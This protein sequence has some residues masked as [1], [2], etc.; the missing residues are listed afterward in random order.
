MA[1]AKARV[2]ELARRDG[3]Q[4]QE[5]G[6]SWSQHTFVVDF[7]ISTTYTTLLYVCIGRRAV[8]ERV[9]R[10]ASFLHAG[11]YA[12][13]D[14]SSISCFVVSGAS[15]VHQFAFHFHS[16]RLPPWWLRCKTQP[17]SL[18]GSHVTDFLCPKPPH[19]YCQVCRYK[20]RRTVVQSEAGDSHSNLRIILT[21]FRIFIP[22]LH[23]VFRH[24]SSS[25]CLSQN[26]TTT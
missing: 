11:P 5:V 7:N 23:F 16:W 10:W 15:P 19:S 13:R 22:S 3:L 14:E 12:L 21:Y 2:T 8:I 9:L 20:K 6:C 18:F 17:Q 25:S 1:Q 26:R 24:A 4:H